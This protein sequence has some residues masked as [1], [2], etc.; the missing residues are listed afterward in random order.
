MPA[1]WN[2]EA[3]KPAVSDKCKKAWAIGLIDKRERWGLTLW[4]WVAVV[5]FGGVALLSAVPKIHGFLASQYPVRGQILVIE[6]WIPDHAIP[7]AVSEFERNG[8]RLLLAVG[9]PIT[10]GSHVSGFKNYA[11]LA[12]VRLKALG[13][14]DR[15]I[16]VLETTDMTKDRTYQSATAVKQWISLNWADLRG[17]DVYTLGVHARRSR[18]LYQKAFG[19]GVAVG[20]IAASEQSYD[21]HN[22]WRSSNGA[23]T[24][25]SE[26]I[27]YLYAAFFFRP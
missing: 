18:L 4:G 1:C 15:H 6:G 24:V 19:D 23:R 2:W 13:V 10:S 22:W 20:V 17:L 9:G 3:E 14:E 27:A 8:Y 21:S 11:E 12:H 26:F 7:G 25:V 5:I 16:V